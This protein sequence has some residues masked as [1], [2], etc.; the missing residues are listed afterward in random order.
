MIDSVII[1]QDKHDFKLELK[2]KT[3]NRGHEINHI[4]LF[5]WQNEMKET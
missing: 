2:L 4:Y 5:K 3:Q 1:S